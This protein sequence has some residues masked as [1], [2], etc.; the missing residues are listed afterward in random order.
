MMHCVT[1][2]TVDHGRVGNIFSVVNE[3]GPDIDKRKERDVGE[4][5]Q[6]KEEGENV[7]WY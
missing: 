6:R 1:S 5:L 7:V 4:F 3:Y 2:C